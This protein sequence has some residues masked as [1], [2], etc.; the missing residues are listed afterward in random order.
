MNK[1][2][3]LYNKIISILFIIL[4]VL[5]VSIYL[6][7]PYY[8]GILISISFL[9]VISRKNK[10]IYCNCL[11]ILI[12]AFISTIVNYPTTPEIFR[13]FSRMLTLIIVMISCSPIINNKSIYKFRC[14]LFSGLSIGLTIVGIVSALLATQGWGFSS[15]SPFLIGLSDYPNNLGYSLAISIMLLC[16][17]IPQKTLYIKIILLGLIGLCIWAIPLTGTRTAFYSL[18]VFFIIYIFLTSKNSKILFKSTIGG[19]LVL[20]IFLSFIKLDMSIIDKKNESQD[21]TNNSRTSLIEGRIK[22]FKEHPILGIGTFVVDTRWAPVTK[23][24]NVETGNT[25]LMFLSMNGIIGFI[26]FIIMYFALLFPFIKYIL[27]KRKTGKIT[28]FEIFLT[29][30]VLYNLITMLQWGILLNAGLYASAINWLTFSLIY[31]PNIYLCNS[32]NKLIPTGSL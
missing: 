21:L 17:L 32:N 9:F 4:C 31:K 12:I 23:G 3:S 20:T 25:F 1:I 28:N 19:L 22:E 26:N 24:G 7:G 13:P 8:Y 27:R 11:L 15:N 16:S 18:P 5:S 2:E 6:G 14:K 29:A 30:I 10:H